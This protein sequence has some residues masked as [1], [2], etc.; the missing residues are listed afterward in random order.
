[1]DRCDWNLAHA[2]FGQRFDRFPVAHYRQISD[3]RNDEDFVVIGVLVQVVVE[4]RREEIDLASLLKGKRSGNVPETEVLNA[5]L[6]RQYFTRT[7]LGVLSEMAIFQQRTS[8]IPLPLAPKRRYF[9]VLQNALIN[10]IEQL[11]HDERIL[12]MLVERDFRF[13]NEAKP[14]AFNIWLEPLD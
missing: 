7:R 4:L 5:L 6:H 11:P 2:S 3:S 12:K 13:T 1:M 10:H 14:L 9:R 8:V